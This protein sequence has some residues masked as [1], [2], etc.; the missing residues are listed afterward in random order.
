M[1]EAGKDIRT[2]MAITGHKDASMFQRYSHP[3]DTHLK[4]AV[5]G[6]CDGKV[7]SNLGT[8][9]GQAHKDSA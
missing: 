1:L 3:S 4:A 7:V 6:L 2:I 9:V 8:P 5:E